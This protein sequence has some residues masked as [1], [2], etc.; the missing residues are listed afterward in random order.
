MKHLDESTIELYVLNALEVQG[1]RA[2]IEKH[3]RECTGCEEL[4]QELVRY[5][6]QAAEHQ[7]A[8]TE[9]MYDSLGHVERALAKRWLGAYELQR[10]PKR[11]VAGRILWS[12]RRHPAKWSMGILVFVV[13]LLLVVPRVGFRRSQLA[14]ARAQ[15]EFLIGFSEEGREIW[16]RHIWFG[17]ELNDR[18]NIDNYLVTADVDRDGNREVIATFGWLRGSPDRNT[19]ICYNSDG[20]ERWRFPFH[21]RMVFGADSISDSYVMSV[22]RVGDF[23][24][25]GEL[26]IAAIAHHEPSFPCALILLRARDME[27]LGEYW[28]PGYVHTVTNRNINGVTELLLGGE[29]NAL[30]Q[31]FL[32]ILDPR[33]VAGYGPTAESLK[34]TGIQPGKEKYYILFPRTDLKVFASHNRNALTVL[35]NETGDL[36]HAA[37]SE[38]VGEAPYAVEYYFDWSMKC[39]KVEQSDKFVTLHERLESEGKLKTVPKEKYNENLRSG[40]LYWDG[41]KFVK[42][43]VMNKKYEEVSRK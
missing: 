7:R 5:Y 8:Q 18:Q 28:H 30:D 6:D 20:S 11:A 39:V 29:N 1:R 15:N 14:Y 35:A 9:M 2:D 25:S 13:L 42:Q 43:A 26:E 36:V 38:W 4:R 23:F 27:L 21:R 41:E 12:V 24:H 16:R 17:Y 10:P 3:L 33:E 40:L 37:I 32:A 22:M 34:P 19:V 31:A